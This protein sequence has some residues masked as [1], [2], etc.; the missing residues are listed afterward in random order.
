MRK[1]CTVRFNRYVKT[2]RKNLVIGRHDSLRSHTTHTA[3]LFWGGGG[4]TRQAM[5][6]KHNIEA[7]SNSHSCLG[8]ELLLLLLLLLLLQYYYYYYYYSITYSESV[9]VALG[10]QHVM[11]VRRIV[12]CDL[13]GSTVFFH[14]IS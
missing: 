8:K 12:I 11:R 10:I 3:C 1:Y 4:G 5:Y 2:F 9:F 7:R 6:V 13:S 14:I